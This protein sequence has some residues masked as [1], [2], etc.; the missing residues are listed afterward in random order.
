MEKM[1]RKSAVWAMAALMLALCL[2]LARYSLC[3]VQGDDISLMYLK[4]IDSEGG[5]LVNQPVQAFIQSLSQWESENP[6]VHIVH[7]ERYGTG[8]VSS[9]A[10]LGKEHLPDVF[11]A[12]PLTGRLLAEYG[13]VYDLTKYVS[14]QSEELLAP[15][16]YDSMVYAFPVLTRNYT[17]VVYDPQAWKSAGYDAFPNSWDA[18]C[19]SAEKLRKMGYLTVVG[20]G[21]QSGGSVSRDLLSPFLTGQLFDNLIEKNKIASFTDPSFVDTLQTLQL[22]LRSD[23]F[24]D[25]NKM[26]EKP[27]N[28]FI[29]GKCAA[30]LLNGKSIYR[31]LEETEETNKT[32]YHRLAFAALPMIGQLGTDG[33]TIP[34]GC[35]YGL[36]VNAKLADDSKKLA[37][38]IDLCSAL[39]YQEKYASQAD[40]TQERLY[41]FIKNTETCRTC[42]QF[43]SGS[44]WA[45]AQ[46][47]CFSKIGDEVD[48]TDHERSLREYA[49]DLQN[50]YE[51]YYMNVDDYSSMIIEYMKPE[52]L[53]QKQ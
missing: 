20:L 2:I 28:A 47:N 16:T 3:Q 44:F 30:L 27:I 42:T 46:G 23:V 7:K 9:L 25:Q 53:Y 33:L 41:R 13:L 22:M 50:Y 19:E 31:L 48:E 24:A 43:L 5:D 4:C 10:Q 35:P 38:C 49:A 15:F 45:L 26:A 21:E 39:A 37:R 29:E 8:E 52:N 11:M 18:L 17:A 34:S 14:G 51:E 6:D 32:L 36:F 1:I 40:E 12:D